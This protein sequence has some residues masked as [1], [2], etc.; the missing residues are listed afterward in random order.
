MSASISDLL[1]TSENQHSENLSPD[2]QNP[3]N[4]TPETQ[5]SQDSQN[6]E[7]QNFESLTAENTVSFPELQQLIVELLDPLIEEVHFSLRMYGPDY[8]FNSPTSISVDQTTLNVKLLQLPKLCSSAE[9]LALFLT[10]INEQLLLT[11]LPQLPIAHRKILLTWLTTTYEHIYRPK[12][13]A[14]LKQQLPPASQEVFNERYWKTFQGTANLYGVD[15]LAHMAT[16]HFIVIGVGGVGSWV[17]ESLARTGAGKIT[18]IDN[19]DVCISNINRQ[20]CATHDSFGEMKTEVM[21][22]RCVAI[23]PLIDVK[24][25]ENFL[26]VNN[27]HELIR[28]EAFTYAA[29]TDDYKKQL[30]ATNQTIYDQLNLQYL[31]E[32]AVVLVSGKKQPPIG[33]P[34]VSSPFASPENLPHS[35]LPTTVYVIDCIDNTTVKAEL[36]EYCRRHK[37]KLV[38][39]GGAGGKTDPTKVVSGDLSATIADP[40]LASIRN[41]LKRN[42]HYDTRFKGKYH[43]PCIYSTEQMRLPEGKQ[44]CD[45]D[46]LNC[47]NGYGSAVVVTATFANLAVARVLAWV[48]ARVKNQAKL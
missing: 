26:T 47:R 9:E 41:R 21:V 15:F 23:N 42:Y 3:E 33:Y 4:L 32:Q 40:L 7:N 31:Y 30:V 6:S 17:A 38:V 20:L 13:L 1:V 2:C 28:G 24:V 48:Q 11:Y 46:S 22:D 35:Y 25:W 36:V 10:F 12:I 14:D 27:F 29:L 45:L 37:F 39:C 44:K 5:D 19:D 34:Y 18:L 8:T 16:S 43:V